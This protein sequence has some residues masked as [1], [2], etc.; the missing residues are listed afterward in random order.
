MKNIRFLI[1]ATLLTLSNHLKS[2]PGFDD[3]HNRNDFLM[4]SPGAMKLGLY[5]YDN[6]ALLNFVQDIDLMFS[7]SDKYGGLNR[8]GF[9]G[10]L[11]SFGVMPPIGFSMVNHLVDGKRITDCRLSFALGSESFGIG[12]GYNLSVYDTDYYERKNT[13]S[14]GTIYRPARNFSLGF[15]GTTVSGFRHYEGVIDLAMRP[16]GNEKLTVF[17]DYALRNNMKVIDGSWSAG[18]AVEAFPGLRITGRYFNNNLF[19][20]GMDFSFG[21]LG[22]ATQ[23]GFNKGFEYSHNTYSLRVGSYERNLHDEVLLNPGNFA[24]IDLNKSMRYQK[25]RHFDDAT[26]LLEKLDLIE[27]LARNPR[28]G[29]IVINTSGMSINHNMLWE[30]REQLKKFQQSG[31]MV[32][33]YIDNADM[34][35]YY[36]A[37]VA[38]LII[39]HPLGSINLPGYIMGNMYFG[40]MLQKIGVGV[41]EYKLH[42]YKSGFE[43]LIR[44]KM[45]DEDRKQR[46]KL[47]DNLYNIVKKDI[48]SSRGFTEEE[49]E[50]LVNDIFYFTAN[51]AHE[52]GLVDRL[53]RWDDI[54]EFIN[55]SAG[56]E[57]TILENNRLQRFMQ[58]ADYSWGAKPLIAV[59]Y[60]VGFCDME[61]GM[62]ARSLAE[63]ISQ[64]RENRNIKA[65]VL[66]VESPGGSTLALDIIA[67]ELRKAKDEK[68]VIVSQGS[69]AASGGYWLS[70]YSDLIVTTPN[71]ITGS[72]GV[73]S[74]WLYNDGIKEKAGLSTDYVKKGE[75]ADLGFG[76]PIPFL[77]LPLLDRT[78]TDQEEEIIENMLNNTYERF[79]NNIVDIRGKEYD[80]VEAISRGRIWSGQDAVELGLADTIGGLKTAISIAAEKAGIDIEEGINIIQLPAPPLYSFSG[81][82]TLLI[83][84]LFDI[85]N[86]EIE[87][88][89]LLQYL[90]FIE[91]HSFQPLPVLPMEYMNHYYYE[92]KYLKR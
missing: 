91:K 6:P 60:A 4:T 26:T 5:G 59:I 65:I 77:N 3:Y 53:G 14:L 16:F 67:E 9:F 81:F 30:L 33:I 66:R 38:N 18:V 57:T 37:S 7:W 31:K 74:G 39:M 48:I 34:N 50:K 90:Q 63:D 61:T 41:K 49:F 69:F 73:I 2:Q 80:E 84:R 8:R 87:V 40:N 54:S 43:S 51:K 85:N 75:F 22:F 72:I 17:Y 86:K 44:D 70:M 10:V 28:I 13:F 25:Y 78:F 36:F 47:V 32:V 21:N 45:S 56:S 1:I 12:A 19:T 71:T 62:R 58:S 11:P 92:N 88:D 82:I 83:S 89:P 27:A 42:E 29:G 24:N 52:H 79:V 46:Q 76:I 20:V 15:T 64:A 68:P 35:T 55:I 23:G